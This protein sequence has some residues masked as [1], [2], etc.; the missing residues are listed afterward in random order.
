LEDYLSNFP[1][2]LIVITHDRYFMDRLAD[3]LF[4]F[5][6]DGVIR[7]FPGNYT[8]FRESLKE[9]AISTEKPVEKKIPS[10]KKARQRDEKKKLSFKEQKEFEQLEKDIE[11]LEQRKSELV[12]QMHSGTA[13]HEDLMKWS[14][15]L[16]QVESMMDEKTNRWLELSEHA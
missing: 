4:V 11:Q 8:D 16:E 3:H 10:E 12:R 15:E 14:K 1:G 2:C 7:D 5:E 13:S 9:E 6:G